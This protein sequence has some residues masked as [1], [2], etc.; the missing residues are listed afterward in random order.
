MQSHT[1]VPEVDWLEQEGIDV[2]LW[3]AQSPDLNNKPDRECVG[4]ASEKCY[5]RC[6]NMIS[7]FNT[8]LQ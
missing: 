2:L 3:P 5:T 7:D 1:A 4:H 8:V 6:G